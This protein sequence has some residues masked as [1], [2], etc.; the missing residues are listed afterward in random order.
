MPTINIIFNS[1]TVT[2]LSVEIYHDISKENKNEFLS[3]LYTTKCIDLKK[4]HAISYHCRFQ[5][6]SIHAL[7]RRER[8][9]KI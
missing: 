8:T 6:P 3:Y 1:S 9:L 7:E 5:C 2:V 4:K